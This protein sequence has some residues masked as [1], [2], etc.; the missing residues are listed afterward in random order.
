MILGV[1]CT[2]L[3]IQMHQPTPEC[4]LLRGA[5]FIFWIHL[6]TFNFRAC[7]LYM[8]IQWCIML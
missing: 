1:L 6:W 4:R 8:Y 3:V 5:S 2:G 7:V